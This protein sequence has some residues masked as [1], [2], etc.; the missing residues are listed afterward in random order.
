MSRLQKHLNAVHGSPCVDLPGSGWRVLGEL[1]LQTI[2]FSLALGMLLEVESSWQRLGLAFV[3]LLTLV[4]VAWAAYRLVHIRRT[5]RIRPEGLAE[6]NGRV[7]P[8]QYL[9]GAHHGKDDR[10]GDDHRRRILVTFTPEGYDWAEREGIVL[11]C[12]TRPYLAEGVAFPVVA[13][14]SREE[15]ADLLTVAIRLHRQQLGL[16]TDTPGTRRLFGHR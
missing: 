16:T 1:L 8:W 3:T 10:G 9:S 7:L 6:R 15:T 14:C 13:G 4:G 12:I 2:L 11:T 5:I